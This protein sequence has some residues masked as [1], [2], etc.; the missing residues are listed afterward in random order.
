VVGAWVPLLE[1]PATG[2]SAPLAAL[3]FAAIG[4]VVGHLV[5]RGLKAN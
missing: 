2:S 5:A 1:I 4:A 3:V